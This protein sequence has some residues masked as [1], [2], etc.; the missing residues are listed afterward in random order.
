MMAMHN[1]RL[2]SMPSV[3]LRRV[4]LDE[5]LIYFLITCVCLSAEVH[6][7][8]R[9]CYVEKVV[10]LLRRGVVDELNLVARTDRPALRARNGF[11]AWGY[12]RYAGLA[13]RV[14]TRHAAYRSRSLTFGKPLR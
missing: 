4:V 6:L 12:S 8:P 10:P 13:E 9:F 3:I 1:I 7:R 14:F 2:K 11:F 5:F